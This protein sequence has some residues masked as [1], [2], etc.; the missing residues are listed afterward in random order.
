RHVHRGVELVHA[1]V[2]GA[3]AQVALEA[4]DHRMPRLDQHGAA[5]HVPAEQSA[6]H[7]LQHLHRLEIVEGVAEP[8]GTRLHHFGEVGPARR[9]AVTTTSPIV[10][11]STAVAAGAGAAGAV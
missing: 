11:L 1:V 4:A 10:A 3:D 7:A 5:G 6:L 2:A 9:R 8:I